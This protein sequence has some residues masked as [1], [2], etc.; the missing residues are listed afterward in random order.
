MK[1]KREPERDAES[2]WRE[3]AG[4]EEQAPSPEPEPET[5]PHS[6]RL[7]MA[8]ARVKRARSRGLR[9]WLPA[10]A[11]RMTGLQKGLVLLLAALAL[12]LVLLLAL[13]LTALRPPKTD[14]SGRVAGKYVFLLAGTD[15]DGVRTDTMMLCA[16]DAA[17]QTAAVMSLPRDTLLLSDGSPAKLNAVYARG[18]MGQEGMQALCSQVERMLGLPIDGYCLLSLE[19]AARA[20][21]LLGGVEFDV[22]VDMQYDDPWQDLHIDLK[23]GRQKLNGQQAVQLLRYR[24]GY[25]NADL[26]RVA[27]QQAFVKAMAKQCLRPSGL[28]KLGGVLRLLS[29]DLVTNLSMGNLGYLGLKLLRMDELRTDTMPGSADGVYLDGQNY[30]VIYGLDTLALLNE[31][32]SPLQSEITLADVEMMRL[33]GQAIVYADGTYYASVP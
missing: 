27:V 26:G 20:V 31:A 17:R 6:E 33:S 5:P 4:Q 3:L 9:A 25:Y 24:S 22:P 21:D 28:L 29:N 10:G 11:W 12:L 7:T 14:G 18:G 15:Q 32:Y 13:A 16:V 8:G 1:R 30:Y 19:T 2:V 23:A